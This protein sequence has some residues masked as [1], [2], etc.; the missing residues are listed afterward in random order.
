MTG[1]T[2]VRGGFGENS[3]GSAPCRKERLRTQLYRG[4]V[5]AGKT[6]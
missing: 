4:D 6:S 1:G 3:I 5:P 2:G